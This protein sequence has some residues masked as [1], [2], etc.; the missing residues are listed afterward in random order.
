MR[1]KEQRLWDRMRS[2]LQPYRDLQLER[3]ENGLGAGMPDVHA[4]AN[5]IMSWVELKAVDVAPARGTTPLL[6]EAHGLLREQKNW[7]FNYIKHRGRCWV[8]IGVG[9]RAVYMISGEHCDRINSM[10]LDQFNEESV[11]KDWQMVAHYLGAKV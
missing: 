7:H 2:K 10:T 3:V 8:L 9:P 1:Q 4:V 11:A 5:G 6:G